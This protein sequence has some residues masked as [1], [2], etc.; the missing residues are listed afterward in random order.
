MAYAIGIDIGGTKIKVGVVSEQGEVVT[1]VQLPAPVQEGPAAVLGTCL[2]AV[3][4]LRQTVSVDIVGI[5][6]ASAGKID[7][8]GVVT[9]STDTFRDWAGTRI[10]ESMK[11]ATGLPVITDNDVNAAALAEATLGA[12]SGFASTFMIALGTGVGGGWVEGGRIVHGAHGGAGEI[13]HLLYL[14]QGRS[15]PCGYAGCFEPYASVHALATDYSL[16]RG[17]RGE[18]PNVMAGLRKRE[19][20]ALEVVGI[21]IK[22]L[23]AL[24]FSVQNAYDPHCIVVGGGIIEEAELWWPML[25]EQVRHLPMEIVMFPARLKSEAAMIGAA[26]LLFGTSEIEKRG[27]MLENNQVTKR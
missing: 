10:S 8:N 20:L 14:A 24:L 11:V 21:W 1:T 6:I 23:E 3:R 27:A 2:N 15:C 19:P 22:T 17:I 16:R 26:C 25:V 9:Y 7:A 12:G 4:S 13:G 18:G 5:G